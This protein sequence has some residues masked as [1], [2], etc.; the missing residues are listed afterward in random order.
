MSTEIPE[1]VIS[2]DVEVSRFFHLTVLNVT[3]ILCSIIT[4]H[5]YV[6]RT[7]K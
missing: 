5:N 6:Q 7:A 1:S 4:D 3:V 2:V